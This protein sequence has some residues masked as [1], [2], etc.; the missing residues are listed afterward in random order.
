MLLTDYIR[1]FDIE[2]FQLLNLQDHTTSRAY[3]VDISIS[4]FGSL[5]DAMVFVN[6]LYLVL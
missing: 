5:G 4:I 3:D 2:A 1:L 6:T